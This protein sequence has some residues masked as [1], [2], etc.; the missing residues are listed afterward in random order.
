LKI[1]VTLEG[2]KFYL[3]HISDNDEDFAINDNDMYG[4]SKQIKLNSYRNVRI[5]YSTANAT[6][7]AYENEDTYDLMEWEDGYPSTSTK[8]IRVFNNFMFTTTYI[9]LD[10]E[11][12]KQSWFGLGM[13]NKYDCS[14]YLVEK[15]T[16]AKSMD[17][18]VLSNKFNIKKSESKLEVI[19]HLWFIAETCSIESG[20]IGVPRNVV[21]L[22]D[23]SMVVIE[24]EAHIYLGSTE[25]ECTLTQIDG[26]H[27]SFTPN[28]LLEY[29]TAYSLQVK[30]VKNAYGREIESAF[31]RGFTTE[32]NGGIHASG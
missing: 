7:P 6:L 30:N 10:L 8:E 24:L 28:S 11:V 2:D 1:K 29:D 17:I 21:I 23:F 31:Y 27:F 14:D 16:T 19:K 9:G 5:L 32:E 22:F 26:S 12:W 3:N 18:S 13:L 20:A 15:Y 25:I 4:Y